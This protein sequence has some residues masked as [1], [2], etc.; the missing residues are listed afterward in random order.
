MKNS[1]ILSIVLLTSSIYAN[2]NQC[3]ISLDKYKTLSKAEMLKIAKKCENEFPLPKNYIIVGKQTKTVI[4]V[5]SIY[6][7]NKI[8]NNVQKQS[9]FNFI[10][11]A[12]NIIANK[13]KYQILK[14]GKIKKKKFTN[15]NKI[16]AK[17]SLATLLEY[18][19]EHNLTNQRIGK[20]I[21]EKSKSYNFLDL[22]YINELFS[23]VYTKED[24]K[25]L[26]NIIKKGNK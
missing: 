6:H 21:I 1:L 19:I 17:M 7:K 25:N 2:D 23:S 4:K 12:H 3:L 10:N 20:L 9:R 8:I 26:L 14:K 15:P 5:N 16:F 22:D 11:K 24:L 18:A 13:N